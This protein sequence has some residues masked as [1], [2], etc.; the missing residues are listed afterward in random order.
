MAVDTEDKR[1]SIVAGLPLPNNSID[2]GDRQQVAGLYRG[3]LSIVISQENFSRIFNVSAVNRVF[4][5]FNGDKKIF[6]MPQDIRIFE[7]R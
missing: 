6:N 1:D 7:A 3:I 2:Q 5:V 4:T